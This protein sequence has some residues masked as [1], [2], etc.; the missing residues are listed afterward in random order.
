MLPKTVTGWVILIFVI[1]VLMY[2][3]SGAFS[4]AGVIIHQIVHGLQT[5]G[6][7]AR[8]GG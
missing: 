8:S 4:Q 3:V 5:F 1:L 6:Q 2:G 7:N